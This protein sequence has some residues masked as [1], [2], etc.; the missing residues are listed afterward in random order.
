LKP[1]KNLSLTVALTD[2]DAKTRVTEMLAGKPPNDPIFLEILS[3]LLIK[4]KWTVQ[5][6]RW[7]IGSACVAGITWVLSHL[8]V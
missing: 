1:D 5:N 4:R 2:L 7:I 6:I 3:L 8:V